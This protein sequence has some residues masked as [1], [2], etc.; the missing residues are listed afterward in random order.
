MPRIPAVWLR[1]GITFGTLCFAMPQFASS[2]NLTPV[3]GLWLWKMSSVLD[4][5]RS[6]EA[7]R[8]F[9]RARAINEV[10]VSFSGASAATCMLPGDSRIADLVGLLH[11]ADIRVEAL[12]SRGDAANPGPHREELLKSV[13]AVLQFN[14]EHPKSRFDGLHLDLEPQQF[15]ENKAAGNLR[16]LPVLV[17]TYAAVRGMVEL[18]GLTVNADIAAKFLKGDPRQRRMLLSALPRLTLMLYELSS[19]N[20]N[21]TASE[22]TEKLRQAS[23]RYLDMAYQGLDNH[24]AAGKHLAR[25]S[26]ALRFTDYTELLPA[27]LR[28]LDEALLSDPHYLGWGWHSYNDSLAAKH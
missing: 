12:L 3:H 4:T 26:I 14:R 24:N 7:L 22:K 5:P 20:D 28:S 10:Y 27:I 21:E 6:L 18:A 1:F 9:C 19:L 25:L 15:P 13:R 17:E 23:R 16:F 2:E 11:Q 8:D